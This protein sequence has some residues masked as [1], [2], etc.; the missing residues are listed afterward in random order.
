MSNSSKLVQLYLNEKKDI[1]LITWLFGKTNK[2]SYVRD[3]LYKAMREERSNISIIKE[4]PV[5]QELKVENKSK[6]KALKSLSKF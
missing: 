5:Q 4:V 3:I 2:S 6:N 1:E